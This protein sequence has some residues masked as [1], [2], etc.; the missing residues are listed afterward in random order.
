MKK[1]R[2]HISQKQWV[3]G[4]G[5]LTLRPV[6][7]GVTPRPYDLSS[8]KGRPRVLKRCLRYR[9]RLAVAVAPHC[10]KEK[11]GE[12]VQHDHLRPACKGSFPQSHY[13]QSVSSS[14]GLYF[15]L[16]LHRR[17]RFWVGIPRFCGSG[18]P[19][20]PNLSREQTPQIERGGSDSPPGRTLREALGI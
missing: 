20:P 8:I 17:P 9:Q 19:I 12:E 15:C 16:G 2:P 10:G 7:T 4:K 13:F 3:I 11:L 6:L 5:H 14:H 1:S 18:S